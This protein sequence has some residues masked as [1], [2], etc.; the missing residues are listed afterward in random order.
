MDQVA[1]LCANVRRA[2][3]AL[4]SRYDGA[5][6]PHGLKVT[7]FSLLR[8]VDRHGTPNLTRLSEATGLDRSTLGRNLRLL[9]GLGFVSL[10]PGQDQRDRVVALTRGG[11]RR[12]RAAARAWAR[13]QG[14][15]SEALGADAGRLVSI[16][17]RVAE[18][19]RPPEGP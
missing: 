6:A 9:E 12:L 1:C 5:L 19:A 10:S 18:L 3:L 8:A 4:T 2:A 13:L 14:S 16:T 17:R 15:L 7:Q 11:R